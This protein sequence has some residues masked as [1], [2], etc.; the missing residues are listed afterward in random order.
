MIEISIELSDETIFIKVKDNGAGIAQEN[1][2]LIFEEFVSIET[3]YSVIG[4]GV[5]LYISKLIT[6]AHNGKIYAQSKGIG[7]GSVITIELPQRF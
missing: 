5:G 7:H 2:K 6:E 3:E 4:T 1:L